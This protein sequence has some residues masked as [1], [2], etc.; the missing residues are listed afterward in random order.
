MI[1]LYARCSTDEQ[2]SSLKEQ[3]RKLR[4]FAQM[5]GVEPFD[6]VYYEDK[7]VSG[8]IPLSER[9]SGAR[10]V[11][12]VRSGD[13]VIAAKV[14]RIF[15]SAVDA[16]VTV[17]DFTKAKI[18]L[19]LL[20]MGMESVTQNGISKM[21]FTLLS[22]FAEFERG[23]IAERMRDGRNAK[24][25]RNGHLGGSAPYGF[26]VVGEGR[27]AKL[28]QI[29]EEIET[30]K[31]VA[32][33]KQKRGPATIRRS[34]IHRNMLDRTGKPFSF[35]QIRRLMNRVDDTLRQIGATECT[36]QAT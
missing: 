1:L 5:Q 22:A 13:M 6:V 2:A 18:N 15:R 33:M 29:P 30:L 7:G 20:D 19:V 35:K 21:F 27:E 3:E 34:L 11:A 10:L 23:R 31:V 25:E 14:D 12:D 9:P 32:S 17:E 28:E 16:L 26:R 4:A 24:K 36:Q 8:A